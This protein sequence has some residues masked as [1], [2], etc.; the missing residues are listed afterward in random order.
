MPAFKGHRQLLR[1][2]DGQALP[3][4]L[5]DTRA[6]PAPWLRRRFRLLAVLFV[7]C[8]ALFWFYNQ[9]NI[10]S[11]TQDNLTDHS[12]PPLYEAY[13]DFERHLPQH[14]LSLPFPEGRD[15]KFFWPAN[16]VTASGWGNA[17]QEL[18]VNALLAHDSNRAFVFDNFT[19]QRNGSEYAEYNGKLIPSRIPLSAIISGPIIGSSFDPGDSTPRA[20]SREYFKKVCPNPTVIDSLTVN[21]HLRLNPDVPAS[22]IFD[23]W[24]ELL[25]S[26]NDPCVEIEES[27]FQIFE[28]WL[29]G[30]N[31]ILSMWPRLSKSPMLL[32]FSWS[33]LVLQTFSQN[34]ELFGATSASFRFLPSFLRPSPA[35]LTVAGLHN[36]DPILPAE[37]TDPIPG[38]FVLH[39]R[40]GDFADHCSHLARWAADWNGFNKFAALPDKFHIPVDGGGG[41][42]TEENMQM[43]H[44]RCFPTIEQIVE[45][46]R[47]VLADQKR[48]YGN[49]KELKRIYIMTNGGVAWLKRLEKALMEVREWDAV[50]TSRDLDLGWEAK[51]VAQSVDMLVGQRAQVF[52]GNGF[53]SLTSNVVMFRMLREL[54]PEDTRFW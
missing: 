28:I 27:S 32:N 9:Q 30:S 19:W 26:I 15:A 42:S 49:T 1:P 5:G 38:L 43:Y 47:D 31:R 17:M 40:R 6:S 8:W 23:K 39:V 54:P 48:L 14:N 10:L 3:I 35:R 16:H 7:S 53:S 37:K 12:L 2:S 45:K 51:H 4:N 18:I 20:V 11:P 13:H 44:Q 21:E 36:V 24:L 50:S 29:F 52:I 34:A 46:V 33:P 22:T 41:K 25:N